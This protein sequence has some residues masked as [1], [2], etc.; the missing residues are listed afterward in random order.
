MFC[1][2]CERRIATNLAVE[3]I[4]PKGLPAYENLKG[5][6]ENFLLGCV[7]CNSTKGQKDVVLSNVLLPNRDNTAAA[8][9]YSMDGKVNVEAGLTDAQK[10]MANRT[11][12][13]TG[14]D[15]PVNEV[16]DSNGRL[17]ALDRVAQRMEIWLMAQD[18]KNDLKLHTN[19]AFR[20]QIAKTA[21][22]SGF[23]SIW[24]TAFEDDVS[25]RKLLILEFAGTASDCFDPD[26]TKTVS[27]R[28][29]NGLSDG[30]KI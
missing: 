9:T 28:P 16:L 5:R 15:K 18:S 14:L 27:P 19:D 7:N 3:H 11:L 4:Q 24:M 29:A 13:L 17:V 10:Q 25:M 20:R 12:A 8:Y 1:S 6:W 2:Y 22:E 23:F 26:T 30:S 21:K